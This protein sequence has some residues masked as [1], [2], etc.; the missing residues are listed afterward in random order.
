MEHCNKSLALSIFNFG[1]RPSSTSAIG[2]VFAVGIV[3]ACCGASVRTRHFIVTAPSRE[4]AE[5]TA[6]AAEHFRR[7][8]AIAWIGDEIPDWHAPCPITVTFEDLAH[9]ETRFGLVQEPGQRGMPVDFDMKLFGPPERIL[10]SVLPHE[11]THTIFATHFG[12]RLPRWAD[13]GACTSVEHSSE[14]DNLK[15]ILL[16]HLVEGKGIPFNEMV[17]M[18]EYPHDML[19]VYSQG[20]SVADFLIQQKGK[21]EF[22]RFIGTGLQS[23]D[24]DRAIHQHFGF[25]DLSDLQLTW[26][27]WVRRG[28][29]NLTEPANANLVA[30]LQP[31]GYQGKYP[32]KDTEPTGTESPIFVQPE[33]PSTANAASGFYFRMQNGQDKRSTS[34]SPSRGPAVY[35]SSGVGRQPGTLLR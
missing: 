16:R 5:R 1:R 3:V 15:R 23:N 4:M 9:G 26:N 18:V 21:R 33:V 19:P 22:V 8:L 24:W 31:A 30:A 6:E 17:R 29:P 13:E 2:I 32:R 12:C 25:Q 28:S 14:T 35:E 10:D 20:Y 7:E 27:E 11:L 34:E